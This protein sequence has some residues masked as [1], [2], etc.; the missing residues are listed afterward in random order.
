MA[1][2][3]KERRR[4]FLSGFARGLGGAA[5]LY[6]APAVPAPVQTTTQPIRHAFETASDTLRSDWVTVGS[7]LDFS[8]KN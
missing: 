3:R 2:N 8:V 5:L 6:A 1:S 4:A 7:D